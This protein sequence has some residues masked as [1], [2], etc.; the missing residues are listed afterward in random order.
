MQRFY[1]L[2]SA[3]ALIGGGIIWAVRLLWKTARTYQGSLDNIDKASGSIVELGE[4]L[5]ELIRLKEREHDRI[6]TRITNV[7]SKVER[8]EQW[9]LDREK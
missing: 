3:L 6:D 2:L 9:H 1:V 7:E 4:D 5:K 8:H